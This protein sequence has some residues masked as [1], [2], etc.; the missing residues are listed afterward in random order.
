MEPKSRDAKIDLIENC[1]ELG[2][3]L[4][5]KTND[6]CICHIGW[7]D[8]GLFHFKV[9][10]VINHRTAWFICGDD[11]SDTISSDVLKS[12]INEFHSFDGVYLELNGLIDEVYC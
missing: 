7:L 1:I 10:L 5:E 9:S 8:D 2:G 3:N 12:R 6:V 11:L 4:E